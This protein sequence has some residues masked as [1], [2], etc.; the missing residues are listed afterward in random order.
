MVLTIKQTLYMT[1]LNQDLSIIELVGKVEEFHKAFGTPIQPDIH[2]GDNKL[3]EL[4]FKLLEEEAK[5]YAESQDIVELTDAIVDALYII[6]GTIAV[7]GLKEHIANLFNIVHNCNM[8]KLDDNG[9]P[10]INGE[11]GVLD[12]SKPIGKILKSKNFI[13]PTLAIEEYLFKAT[14]KY[15]KL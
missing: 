12:P 3:R 11:N 2:F 1:Q 7:H 10:I 14:L 9:K 4:R 15:T 13:D 5:E 8:S 6:A